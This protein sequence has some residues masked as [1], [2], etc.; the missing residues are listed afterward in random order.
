MK[1]HFN[2]RF[3]LLSGLALGATL[4]T[5]GCETPVATQR[6]PDITFA[7][8]PAFKFDVANIEVVSRFKAPLK[9]PHIEHQLPTSPETALSQW[10]KDRL[11]AVGNS[12]TLRLTIEDA[13]ATETDLSRDTS[14][15]GSFT[16]QQSQRYDAAVHAV[17]TLNDAGG[18]E[19]GTATAMA[20]RS[21]TVREDINLNDR[22]RT[23]FDLVDHLLADFNGQMEANIRQHLAPWLR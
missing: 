3:V 19:R 16:K 21:I 11:R 2:R 8:L 22:E 4:L 18:R 5:Q 14:F 1:P 20:T 12:G 17:L 7:H 23:Q 13:S 9:E 10:A 6:L 15:K